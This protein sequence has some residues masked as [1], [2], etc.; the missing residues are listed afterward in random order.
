MEKLN[1]SNLNVVNLDNNLNINSSKLIRK[2]ETTNKEPVPLLWDDGSEMLW[3][4]NMRIL[5]SK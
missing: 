4:N 5:I 2:N 1:V 3:D